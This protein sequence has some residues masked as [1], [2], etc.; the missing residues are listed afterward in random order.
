MDCVDTLPVKQRDGATS[1]CPLDPINRSARGH[2]QGERASR[3][4]RDARCAAATFDCSHASSIQ[5]QAG[6]TLLFA[7]FFVGKVRCVFPASSVLSRPIRT[8]CRRILISAPLFFFFVVFPSTKC[9]HNTSR[10]LRSG[11]TLQTEPTAL[12]SGTGRPQK[13][14]PRQP[15]SH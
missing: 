8:Q 4:F 5:S 10:A 9:P 3:G 15:H 1:H 2:L 13:G 7:L 14:T 11:T 12:E 6:R